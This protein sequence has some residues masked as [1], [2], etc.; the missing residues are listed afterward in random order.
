MAP[1]NLVLRQLPLILLSLLRQ[2]IRGE[3]LLKDGHAF[4]A[5]VCQDALYRGGTPCLFPG[6]GLD[7]RR[8]KSPCYRDWSIP[9]KIASV[10]CPHHLGLLRVNLRLTIRSFPITQKMLILERHL[11]IGKGFSN[12]PNDDSGP[13]TPRK[14]AE[15]RPRGVGITPNK[16]V[17]RDLKPL[18][19]SIERT[20]GIFEKT[21]VCAEYSKEEDE[22][23]ARI[24]I[25]IPK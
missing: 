19:T 11:P 20:L 5:F 18:Y 7:A 13:K 12:T 25:R 22:N 24:T 21:G 6:G 9:F 4:I 10:D 17:L 3:P 8:R 23:Y 16:F 15:S 14:P 2:I 1:F